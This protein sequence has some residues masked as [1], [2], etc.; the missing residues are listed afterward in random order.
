MYPLS[1][2]SLF[3]YNSINF[4]SYQFPLDRHFILITSPFSYRRHSFFFLF[5]YTVL[6]I[7]IYLLL[8]YWP[9]CFSA[10]FSTHI[11]L[12]TIFPCLKHVSLLL[13]LFSLC[14]CSFFSSIYS[15]VISFLLFFLSLS[16]PELPDFPLGFVHLNFVCSNKIV[17]SDHFRL[18]RVS[19]AKFR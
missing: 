3:W 10:N 12:Y 13:F 11:S 14:L 1:F 2:S 17:P 16:F 7:P 19:F 5:F 15:V 4:L 8:T 18:W 9:Q 6:S